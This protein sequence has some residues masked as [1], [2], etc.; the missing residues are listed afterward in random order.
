M[1]SKLIT[2]WRS[3]RCPSCG[4]LLDPKS[5][6]AGDMGQFECPT[7]RKSL[8][9]AISHQRPFI[10]GSLLSSVLIAWAAG[11]RGILLAVLVL[12]LSL[13]ILVLEYAVFAFFVPLRVRLHEGNV[14]F[15]S[16]YLTLGISASQET[17]ATG[18][19]DVAEKK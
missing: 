1:W 15:Q 14:G 17:R 12:P 8:Y 6:K 11:A 13:P 7:C 4:G 5:I 16:D 10:A 18:T 9:V 2:G 3:P 19:R